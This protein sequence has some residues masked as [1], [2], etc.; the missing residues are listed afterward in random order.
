KVLREVHAAMAAG[1]GPD[2]FR[3]PERVLVLLVPGCQLVP[4]VR[5]GALPFHI[6]PARP[7]FHDPSGALQY[8]A[9][10]VGPRIVAVV[11]QVDGLAPP[12]L[13]ERDIHVAQL[14]LLA[15]ARISLGKMLPRIALQPACRR[16]HRD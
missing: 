6:D 15:A 9:P 8:Q 3:A 7:P 16:A 2:L 5:L 11:A 14:E 4:A 10:A 12:G 1:G 13:D